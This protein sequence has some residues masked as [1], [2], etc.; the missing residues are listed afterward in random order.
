M[1]RV[2]FSILF[3]FFILNLFSADEE[4]TT[5]FN[6]GFKSI[7][8]FNFEKAD[9]VLSVLNANY[10][11]EPQTQI[12]GANFFWWKIRSGEDNSANRKK[13]LECLGNLEKLLDKKKREK[14]L[15]QPDI[16]HY[17]NLYSYR[18]R[19]EIFDNHYIRALTYTAKCN[20]YI[21]LS[22]DFENS[23][24]PFNLTSG[25]YNCF[26]AIAKE[27]HPL[28]AP[29]FLFAPACDK[30]KGLKQLAKC[31]ASS[32]ILLQTEANYFLMILYGEQEVDYNLSAFY[33]D[34]LLQK[35]SDNLLYQYYLFKVKLFSGNLESAMKNLILLFQKSKNVSGLTDAQRKYFTDMAG[36][37]MQEYYKKHPIEKSEN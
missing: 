18:A 1:K 20:S 17:I 8:N 21:I 28:A 3:S 29:Y 30:E 27:N 31:S 23:Y 26:M 24:E 15:S 36:K 35:Y 6:K 32:D 9:S 11:S 7:Y 22:S 13:Y 37:D 4:F 2:W 10:F 33:A 12:L 16:F 34:K 5:L 25:L 14:K 19:I